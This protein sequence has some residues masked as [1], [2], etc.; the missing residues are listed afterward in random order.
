MTI[1]KPA[2]ATDDWNVAAPSTV[3]WAQLD[4]VLAR[5]GP[6]EAMVEAIFGGGRGLQ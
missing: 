3:V 2:A 1:A 4:A 5:R 6:A